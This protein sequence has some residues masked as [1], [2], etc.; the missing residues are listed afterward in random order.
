MRTPNKWCSISDIK[1]RF[2]PFFDRFNFFW[3]PDHTTF[4]SS[5]WWWILWECWILSPAIMEPAAW[6]QFWNRSHPI[7]NVET[8]EI[9][10]NYIVPLDAIKCRDKF[11][12]DHLVINL[13]HRVIHEPTFRL[14][15]DQFV[16]GKTTQRF[17]FFFIHTI[18]S[19]FVSIQNDIF[20]DFYSVSHSMGHS[21]AYIFV[22]VCHFVVFI[23]WESIE[24]FIVSTISHLM[25][26]Y[27]TISISSA[28]ITLFSVCYYG[29]LLLFQL[30]CATKMT[31]NN[32]LLLLLSNDLTYDQAPINGTFYC[33]LNC[34]MNIEFFFF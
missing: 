33:K 17:F 30:S 5:A 32:H 9:H 25:P 18:G 34:D 28:T 6:Y 29:P 19:G 3:R 2:K 23:I 21:N 4:H 22:C 16:Y 26:A 20:D 14:S 13:N 1:S 10:E 11:V 31:S 12:F 8:M 15:F 24:T 27:W 7:D